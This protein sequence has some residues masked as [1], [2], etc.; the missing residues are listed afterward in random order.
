M[1]TSCQNVTSANSVQS[2]GPFDLQRAD[3]PHSDEPGLSSKEEARLH[4]LHSLCILDTVPE[5]E[6]DE[7]VQLAAAI[8]GTP[9]GMLSFVDERRQWFKSC[10]GLSITE[11]PRNLAFCHHTIQQTDLML[12][13]DATLDPRFSDS[14]MVTGEEGI[15]FYAGMPL[16]TSEG[17]TL[18]TLCVFDR[19][20]RVLTQE[21][22]AALR[23]LASQINVRLELR[24]QH[25]AFEEAIRD[26]QAAKSLAQMLEQRFQTFMDSGPFLA[27]I[28]DSDG[29]MLYYNE[30]MAKQFNV[31][32]DAL[33]HKTD[34]DLWPPELAVTYRMND[35]SAL[36]NGRLHLSHE[37]TVNPNG[38]TSVWRSYKFPYTDP[39]GETLIGGVCVEVTKELHRQNELQHY[40]KELEAANGR[41]RELASVDALTGL[42]NRR[43]FDEQ[44][45][46]AFRAARQSSGPLSVLMLDV[47]HFKRHNDRF[48]HPHGDEVL[49]LLADCLKSNVRNQDLIARYRGEEF[50]L[51]LPDTAAAE[52]RALSERLLHAIRC[53]RWPLAPVTVSIGLSTLGPATRDTQHLLGRADE[54]LYA[55]KHS[56]RDRVVSYTHETNLFD[57]NQAPVGN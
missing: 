49:R 24:A 31:S 26:A 27:F 56:G 52:A 45:R 46:I 20:P 54:A 22:Q 55:A 36:R 48:G 30:P 6:F 15:R 33:L 3:T 8:C 2:V 28:K 35:L 40:Q 32:R 5:P 50:V 21:Q 37:E 38:S 12:V 9:F 4:A 11:T 16:K 19:I 47:D 34:E 13:E 53:T 23:I 57:M 29:R 43:V 18:G 41:L 44:F 17:H 42:S 25:R 7:L 51:L 10:L 1:S 14:C 39:E